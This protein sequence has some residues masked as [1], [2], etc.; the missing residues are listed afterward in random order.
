MSYHLGVG[1]DGAAQGCSHET[2]CRKLLRIVTARTRYVPTELT[3]AAGVPQ[4]AA[5]DDCP[6]TQSG[7][8]QPPVPVL[9]HILATVDVQLPVTVDDYNSENDAMNLRDVRFTGTQPATRR[10]SQKSS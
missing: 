1:E 4:G 2:A 7:P 3:G 8:R 5:V 10:A 6:R 9:A